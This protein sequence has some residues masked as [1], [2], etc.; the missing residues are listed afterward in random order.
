A[1]FWPEEAAEILASGRSLT[2][3]RS[4]GPWIGRIVEGLLADDT[5]E[6][7]P[8]PELRR[9][10]L[11]LAEVRRTLAGRDD[12]QAELKGDLQSHTTY[13]DGKAMLREM[14]EEAE[15]RGY[16]YLA[17]TDHSKGLP[18]ANGM[19]EEQLAEQGQDVAMAND[20]LTARG[21]SLRILHAIEMNLSPEGE[22]DMD[23]AALTRLNIIL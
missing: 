15:V 22:G 8:S 14:A 16:R 3:L 9:D 20:E 7:P 2:E 13:S 12:W 10:F 18:I 11:T 23:P 19:N 5:I 21:S 1:F 17:V 6:P 4:V